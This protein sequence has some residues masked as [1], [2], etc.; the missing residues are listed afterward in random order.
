[1]I[2]ALFLTH[3]FP[4]TPGDPVG[5]FVLRLAVA[6]RTHD[7]AVHV[8]APAAPDVPMHDVIDDI[9][10]TRYRYAPRR[11]ETLAYTGTMGSQARESWPGRLA[12]LGLLGASYRAAR[13]VHRS[14]RADVVHA[15]WWF[16]GGLVARALYAT[17]G[18][19]YVVTSHGSDLRLARTVPGAAALYRSVSRQAAAMTTVSS[20][21]AAEARQLDPRCNP[22]V[23]PMPVVPELFGPGGTHI[24]NRLLFIGKLTE[25][26]GLHHLLHAMSRMQTRA[27]LDVVGAGRVDDSVVRTLAVDLGV[28]DRITWHPLL[29][30]ADLAER[31]RTAAAHVIPAVGEGLGLTAVESLLSETPVVAFDSGGLPDVVIP[32]ETGLLVPPGD[33]AALTG[34]L[35]K[36]LGDAALRTRLGA[37]GRRFALSHFGPDAVAAQYASLLK[38]AAASRAA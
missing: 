22:V 11:W 36:I 32:G 1:V 21:L 4:R 3:N 31:Y 6:L 14:W 19:P 23:A 26:K 37:A 29:S 12:M 2:R 7:V 15:H 35:D 34:A 20:W 25:Q 38:T 13:R 8:V 18:T 27:T 33:T 17:L 5:S 9:P 16:P 24:A 30:Q 28:A 10:V